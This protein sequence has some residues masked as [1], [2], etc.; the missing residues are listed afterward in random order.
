MSV[1]VPAGRALSWEMT[2]SD[3]TPVVRERYWLS[4]HAGEVR[5]CTSCHGVN[6]TD[7]TG[8]PPATNSPAALQS[9][10]AHWK[11]GNP[12][13]AGPATPYSVWSE[14]KLGHAS[15][16]TMTADNDGDGLTNLEEFVYGSDPR[17]PATA[18]DGAAPLT[19]TRAGSD[20]PTTL[21]FTR[22]LDASGSELVAESSPDLASWHE[23]A[24]VGDAGAAAAPGS[25][26]TETTTAA[27]RLLRL[28]AWEVTVPSPPDASRQFLRLRFSVP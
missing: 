1:L 15:A 28:S 9:L 8:H 4:F 16:D 6:R 10:L 12:E 21:R 3:G 13:S 22:N 14:L 18:A 17:A 20:G 2:E 7:Q 5:M 25:T 24:R 23:A 19:A 11:S 26:V 27:Q